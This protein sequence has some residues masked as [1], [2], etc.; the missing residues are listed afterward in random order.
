MTKPKFWSHCSNCAEGQ[1]LM[2]WYIF[3]F[4]ECEEC[5][6]RFGSE[7]GAVCKPCPEHCSD[8]MQRGDGSGY[9]QC[10]GGRC[11]KGYNGGRKGNIGF[12]QY[13][14]FQPQCQLECPHGAYRNAT[15]DCAACPSGIDFI[16]HLSCPK[17]FT[18]DPS[19]PACCTNQCGE[20]CKPGCTETG[21][22]I[23]CKPG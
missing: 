8:C 11:D 7:G 22:C 14:N 20:H 18:Q 12:P 15:G 16:R 19:I 5:L 2:R 21:D 23:A 9:P 17:G 10:N 13:Y 3:P 4:W 6:P 1:C